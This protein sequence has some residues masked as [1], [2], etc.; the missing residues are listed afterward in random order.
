MRG[1][2]RQPNGIRCEMSLNVKTATVGA[3]DVTAL[4]HRIDPARD[5]V[6]ER[7]TSRRCRRRRSRPGR[8]ST[9]TRT[10]PAPPASGRGDG[11]ARPGWRSGTRRVQHGRDA[12]RPAPVTAVGQQVVQALGAAVPERHEA[13]VFHSVLG[14]LLLTGPATVADL[15]EQISRS[16]LGAAQHA[17]FAHDKRR[18]RPRPCRR[19]SW[20][21]RS[22]RPAGP[23]RRAPGRRPAGSD[24]TARTAAASPSTS[25]GRTTG[26]SP[27]P[28]PPRPAR[29]RSTR[30][31][32]VPA[33]AASSATMPNGS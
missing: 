18:R 24:S 15:G 7:R 3:N 14:H 19:R 26:R 27:R 9:P 22:R 28:A 17:W 11:R 29:R 13:L 33:A 5:L 12:V 20:P 30:P 32:G 25:P 31:A 16:D 1:R 2:M 8:A 10:G 23:S 6:A 4:H 21:S